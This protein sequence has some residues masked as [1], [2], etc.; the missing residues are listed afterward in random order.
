MT[1]ERGRH[2]CWS[3][4]CQ[5]SSCW[6]W[7]RWSRS[8]RRW[9]GYRQ[10]S[11]ILLTLVP[12]TGNWGLLPALSIK[13]LGYILSFLYFIWEQPSINYYKL[14]MIP[15]LRASKKSYLCLY[16]HATLLLRDRILWWTSN[17]STSSGLILSEAEVSKMRCLARLNHSLI[18]ISKT[19]LL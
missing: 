9:H 4:G 16:P 3:Y 18:Y 13:G 8:C 11:D 12:G 1:A 5:A 6:H 10:S 17:P 15:P 7:D 14:L 2:R 19:F